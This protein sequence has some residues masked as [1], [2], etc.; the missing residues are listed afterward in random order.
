MKKDF[1]VSAKLG[2]VFSDGAYGNEKCDP[3]VS[4][5]YKDVEALPGN[6]VVDKDIDD[7]V[8]AQDKLNIKLYA[9]LGEAKRRSEQEALERMYA[10]FRWYPVDDRG[11]KYPSVTTV[12]NFANPMSFHIGKDK[13]KGYAARG[14]VLDLI[15]QKYIETGEWLEPKQI[16][17]CLSW[18]TVMEAND[19]SLEGNL[20]AFVDKYKLRFKEA[21]KVVVNH[22]H[23]YAGEMDCSTYIE[24]SPSLYLADLKAF[25]SS[26][27]D[28]RTLKA[29]KQ[30]AA[31]VRADKENDYEGGMLMP[32]T[33]K[34]KCGF[35]KMKIFDKE[36]IEKYFKAFLA[37][38][39]IFRDRIGI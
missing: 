11:K 6:E 17:E 1:T 14:Q 24:G 28:D 10:D 16:P 3:L 12:T 15:L 26:P 23:E 18:L 27:S 21:H 31:Y 7:A 4:I 8:D 19:I 13:L 9:R 39:A 35:A 22:E 37:D 5:T 20:P 34:N 2:G 29:A 36:E 33:G 32:L 30:I 38:R 25:Y